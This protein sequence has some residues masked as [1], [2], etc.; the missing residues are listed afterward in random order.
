MTSDQVFVERLIEIVP[1]L[2][3]TFNEHVKDNGELLPHVF[4]GDVTRWAIAHASRLDFQDAVGRL[5]NSLEDGLRS[6]SPEVRELILASFVENLIGE[7]VAVE[8]LNHLMGPKLKGA[9]QTQPGIL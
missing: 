7:R 6:G 8:Q 4:M 2:R 3:P 5:L 1:E 9:I